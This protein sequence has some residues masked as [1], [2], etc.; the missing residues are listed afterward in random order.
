MAQLINFG[1]SVNPKIY[2]QKNYGL[3]DEVNEFEYIIVNNDKLHT[4]ILK[5]SDD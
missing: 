5:N 1:D 2:K 4:H 3:N